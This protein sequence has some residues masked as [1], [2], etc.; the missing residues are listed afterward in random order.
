MARLAEWVRGAFGVGS[1][2]CF[3]PASMAGGVLSLHAD[4]RAEDAAVDARR[5]FDKGWR[6]FT[7]LIAHADQIKLQEAL[8]AGYL[9]SCKNRHLGIRGPGIQQA[10]HMNHVHY[11]VNYW[12]ADNF[13]LDWLDVGPPAPAPGPSPLPGPAPGPSGGMIDVPLVS[14]PKRKGGDDKVYELSA[15]QAHYVPA[16]THDGRPDP[17]QLGR[18]QTLVAQGRVWEAD[19]PWTLVQWF[20]DFGAWDWQ[21]NAPRLV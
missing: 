19:H 21:R 11:G 10:A 7:W 14:C 12:C 9:W 1:L 16:A 4:G 2:G 13:S 20:D 17:A 3:N 8:Y 6:L 15:G 5:E 18:V